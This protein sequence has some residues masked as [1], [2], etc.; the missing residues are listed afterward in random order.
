MISGLSAICG[1]VASHGMHQMTRATT[2]TAISPTTSVHSHRCSHQGGGEAGLGAQYSVLVLALDIWQNQ[3][4]VR[5]WFAHTIITTIIHHQLTAEQSP[6]QHS[7][8]LSDMST[9]SCP[10]NSYHF[11]ST[12]L[13]VSLDSYNFC[14]A[15]VCS[16]HDMTCPRL[17]LTIIRQSPNFSDSLSMM[18]SA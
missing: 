2:D 5:H 10:G 18:L 17:L 14:V 7:P 9:A 1:S 4:G 12:W 11:I 6:F 8:L 15:T 16:T 3:C 13:L